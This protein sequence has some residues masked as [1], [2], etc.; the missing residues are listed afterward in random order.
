[1]VRPAESRNRVLMPQ[2]KDEASVES[3]MR[4]RYVR[5][6][7]AASGFMAAAGYRRFYAPKQLI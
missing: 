6:T 3:R 7:W 4:R 1:L 2:M 5:L